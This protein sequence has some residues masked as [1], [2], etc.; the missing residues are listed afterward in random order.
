[1]FDAERGCYEVP[2]DAQQNVENIAIWRRQGTE[3]AKKNVKKKTAHATTT[4]FVVAR[5]NL[6]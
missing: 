3:H 5:Q 1:M 4:L 2:D 6:F